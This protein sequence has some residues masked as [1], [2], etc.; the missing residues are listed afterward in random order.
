MITHNKH[1]LVYLVLTLVALWLGAC[2]TQGAETVETLVPGVDSE[3]VLAAQA[4]VAEQLGTTVEQIE[5]VSVEQT[6]W[7]DSCLGLGQAN[8]SCAAVVT[9]GWR[10]VFLVD[11]QEYEVRTDE[12]G[13]VI[14][15][16]QIVT[17]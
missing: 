4:W 1:R 10:A 5:V 14:R 11:G 2:S 12:T 7:S 16:A 8:E 15:S 17:E 13:S 3:A 9:P 6:E